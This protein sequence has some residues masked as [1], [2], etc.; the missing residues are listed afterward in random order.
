MK[1]KKQRI[2]SL[3]ELVYKTRNKDYGAFALRKKYQKYTL[4]SLLMGIFIIGS[5][6]AYPV[7]ASYLN[8]NRIV[9]SIPEP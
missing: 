8:K 1:T 4:I 5:V 7:I 6:V 2:E 9:S 3:E